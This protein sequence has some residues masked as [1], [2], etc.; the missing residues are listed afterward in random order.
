MEDNSEYPKW[1]IFFELGKIN[2]EMKDNISALNA[3]RKSIEIKDTNHLPFLY[4]GMANNR[5]GKFQEAINDFTKSLE[6][7]EDVNSYIERGR[8]FN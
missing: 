3:L 8:A 4:K 2:L 5:L 7:K 6:I 1:K